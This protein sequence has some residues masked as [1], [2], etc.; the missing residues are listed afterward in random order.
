[1]DAAPLTL[2]TLNMLLGGGRRIAP[3][4]VLGETGADVLFLQEAP[5]PAPDARDAAVWAPAGSRPWGSAIVVSRGR[6]RPLPLEDCGGWVV[7]A[8]WH[9]E[10][11]EPVD[12]VSVHVPQGTRGFVASLHAVLDQLRP[13][14]ATGL[15]IGGDFNICISR[16]HHTGGPA[17]DAELEVQAR[18]RDEF[19]LVGCWD[20]LHPRGRPPQTLR[21]SGDRSIPYHC[22]GLF[23]PAAWRPHL[24][25]CV[26][27]RSPKWQ[28]RSDHLPVLA[29]F[30]AAR[31]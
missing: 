19:G 11:R 29:R 18:L 13:Y 23:V 10:G 6:V 9:V 7:A 17:R 12:L 28:G 24:D 21:W 1:M 16:R 30:G 27:L 20:A 5:A 2:A 25:R 31:I 14:R 15:V 8:R 26:V 22:D 4:Q 3:A